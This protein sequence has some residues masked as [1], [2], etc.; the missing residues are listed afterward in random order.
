MLQDDDQEDAN[1]E[2]RTGNSR[3]E[4]EEEEGENNDDENGEEEEDRDD[5]DRVS[6]P[7]LRRTFFSEI[8]RADGKSQVR[9]CLGFCSADF[10]SSLAYKS[11]QQKPKHCLT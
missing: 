6:V 3:A 9:Q 11:A 8:I 7:L 4:S 5:D 1:D 2:E 10:W